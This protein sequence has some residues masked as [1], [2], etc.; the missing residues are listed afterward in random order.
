MRTYPS[1][2]SILLAGIYNTVFFYSAYFGK[3]ILQLWIEN[4]QRETTNDVIGE[5][6][7]KIYDM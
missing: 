4:G 7:V 3:D 1:Y 5:D 6:T 2:Y